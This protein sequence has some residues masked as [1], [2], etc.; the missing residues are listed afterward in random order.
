MTVHV[1]ATTSTAPNGWH[2]FRLFPTTVK[3]LGMSGT[4]ATQVIRALDD[5]PAEMVTEVFPSLHSLLLLFEFGEVHPAHQFLSLRRLHGRP[6]TLFD[7]FHDPDTVE[8]V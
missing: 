7:V 3:T 5:I 2:F 6:V 1:G 8:A 4:L